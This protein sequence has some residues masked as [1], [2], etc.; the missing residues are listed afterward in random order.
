M[1]AYKINEIN[2][3]NLILCDPIKNSLLQDSN[4]YKLLYSTEN[5]TTNGVFILFKLNNYNIYKDK[6]AYNINE[7]IELINNITNIENHLLNKLNNYK[8]KNFKLQE[9]FLNSNIKYS[10]SENY[11][12][13]ND[14]NNNNN[15][16]NN[17]ITNLNNS[18]KLFVLKLSGIWETKDNLGITF[19]IMLI[20]K[21]IEF[22][23]SVEK[24]ANNI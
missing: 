13:N 5:V 9:L 4:F 3:N 12:P 16:N 20:N 22:Y 2:K 23:P 15:N 17:N 18:N 14:S 11:I 1:F 10:Y 8:K 19:K 21:Y 24:N 6:V 7:N